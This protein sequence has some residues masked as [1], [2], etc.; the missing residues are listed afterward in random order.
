MRHC[1]AHI[2]HRG[3]AATNRGE[4]HDT[5]VRHAGD[6][7]S[8][9]F[10]WRKTPIAASLKCAALHPR[11]AQYRR[12]N[13]FAHEARQHGDVETINTTAHPQQGNAE[14]DNTSATKKRTQ[15]T[16]FSPAK[17]TPVSD[18]R[19]ICPTRPGCDTRGR[20]GQAAT[21]MR[22]DGTTAT[23]ISHVI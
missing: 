12:A 17:A 18:N 15:S 22:D 13:F 10:A 3:S 8:E 11:P 16:R 19:P 21:P 1:W 23:H 9:G 4:L 14:T 5:G 20:Q 7:P 6:T 2:K